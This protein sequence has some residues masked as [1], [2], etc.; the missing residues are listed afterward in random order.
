M[1]RKQ[2]PMSISLRP[3]CLKEL[4]LLYEVNPRTIKVWLKRFENAIGPKNGRYYTIRQVE[5]I[6]EKIGEPNRYVPI[7]S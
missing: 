7:A 5:V 6:F 2:M 3:Y 4:A 1:E